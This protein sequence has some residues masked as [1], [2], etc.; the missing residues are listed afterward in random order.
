[1]GLGRT[2]AVSLVGLTGHV[3]EVEAHLAAS[4]PGFSLV[5]LPDA[6]LA[7]SRDRVRA[8]VTSSA[9]GWPQ[10]RITVNLSPA[11]LP[12]SGSGFDL[13]IAVAMLA[14]AGVIPTEAPGRIVHLGELGLDGRLRPIRGVLPAV[15]AAVAA[16]HRHIVVPA[17][18]EL[19]AGLVPG[20][21][22][23]GAHHLA[24]VASRY[25]AEVVV[26]DAVSPT[27]VV[28]PIRR[29]PDLDLADV[30]GQDDA[31]AALEVAASGGHHLLLVGPPGAGKTMLAARL[32]G[33]LPDLTPDEAVEVTAVHSVAGTFDPADG[34]I[35]RPPFE[36]PHHTA[37][38]AAVVGGGS[39]V[40]RPGAA[41]RA[42]R[43]VLFMD[44][45]CEPLRTSKP[46][47]R[48]WPCLK[49]K[50]HSQLLRTMLHLCTS[51]PLARS[52]GAGSL[53]T[54]G[55]RM[56]RYPA[57]RESRCTCAAQSSTVTS[58]MPSCGSSQGSWRS[59]PQADSRS[60]RSTA[61]TIPRRATTPPSARG[62]AA[63]YVTW[64][65][66]TSQT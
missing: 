8:A 54:S 31:R 50:P 46:R 58:L 48:C 62:T 35:R 3:V 51:V 52:D 10:R 34:L 14:G 61:T 23:V 59:T 30:V 25:G 28:D 40:P 1:M 11:S 18:N 41:S 9:L 26:P 57:P 32:P 22:V 24:E 43:G 42:H 6:A 45:S 13:A 49:T 12:K 63:C 66:A 53:T 44:E 55:L 38:A 37:T 21:D 29:A 36:D 17:A 64:T 4:V 15:A 20:A 65:R 5:G 60:W 33:L 39:G 2:L 19:E 47:A 16:G 56:N 7:E 27:A